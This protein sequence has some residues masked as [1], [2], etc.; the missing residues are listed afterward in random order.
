MKKQIE[1]INSM[2]KGIKKEFQATEKVSAPIFTAEAKE[3]YEL[4]GKAEEIKAQLK[5]RIVKNAK[6]YD[7]FLVYHTER[8]VYTNE[9]KV[10][11]SLLAKGYSAKKISKPRS[12]SQLKSAL[13]NA[14]EA[15]ATELQM[16]NLLG[17][18]NIAAV[19]VKA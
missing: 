4:L 10:L 19:K 14:W 6:D 9:Q 12:F 8:K 1:E 2:L 3:L 13:G 16:D 7:D 15:V 18:K 5:Q 17:V 11:E